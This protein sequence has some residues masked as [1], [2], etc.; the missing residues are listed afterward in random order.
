MNLT[1]LLS[2][3]IFASMEKESR[4]TI[5]EINYLLSEVQRHYGR[6]LATSTDFEALSVVIE[7]ESG[8]LL[9][10]STLK[11]LWGYVTMKP[12]PR[13]ST[14]DV[15]SRFVGK[16]DFYSFCK[17]IKDNSLYESRFF[18]TKVVTS[19]ELKPG[20]GLVIGWAPDR[21]VH[22]RYDGEDSFTV[23]ASENSKLLEGDSFV[24][25]CFSLGYPLYIPKILRGGGY[26]PSYIAGATEG[27]N[28][29]EVVEA[30]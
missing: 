26:T 30:Q 20:D 11:R 4:K 25:A 23:T 22:L 12:N 13:Q 2:V 8:E 3:P 21:L 6:R 9:S 1:K 17:D 29:V 27:L 5:P 14:L 7:H 24:A 28:L 15:L 10:A 18:S 19:S 16:R